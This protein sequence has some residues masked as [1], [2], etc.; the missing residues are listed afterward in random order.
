VINSGAPPH[1][2]DKARRLSGPNPE[3]SKLS[4]IERL[5]LILLLGAMI[6]QKPGSDA[7]VTIS[8]VVVTELKKLG[9]TET[10]ILGMFPRSGHCYSIVDVADMI[11]V[12]PSLK[13]P[14]L[15]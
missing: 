8:R 14:Y 12:H 3:G 10:A 5:H 7:Q 13:H 2:L 11:A 1:I 15:D 4:D 6:D 9:M